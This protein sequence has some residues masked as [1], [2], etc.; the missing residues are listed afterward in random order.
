VKLTEAQAAG[1]VEPLL[2]AMKAMAATTNPYALGAFGEGL[3]EIAQRVPEDQT[4]VQAMCAALRHPVADNA[5]S[6]PVLQAL[7]SHFPRDLPPDAG[8]WDV[9]R[10]IERRFAGQ[11]DVRKPACGALAR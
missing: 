4:A 3:A 1:A 9:A 2:K 10:L 8:V 5:T 6:E 11:I 7:R